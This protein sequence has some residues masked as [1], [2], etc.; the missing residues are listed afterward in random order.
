LPAD[1]I[2]T[3]YSDVP[4]TAASQLADDHL[5]LVRQWL[6]MLV[7]PADL[8]DVDFTTFVRYALGFFVNTDK[9]W[10]KD[11][12]GLH[13]IVAVPTARL[14]ILKSAHDDVAHKGFYA[15]NALIALWFWWP[16]MRGNIAWWVRTCRL[17]QLRQMRN[18]LILPVV[19]TPTSLFAKIYIDTM[20]LPKSGGYSYIVQGRCSVCH[21]V[22]FRM[23]RHKTGTTIGDWIF[24]DILCQ[25]GALTE[26]VTDNGPPFI[27]ALKYLVRKDHVRHIRISGYNL[28][29]NGLV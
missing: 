7:W 15:T 14:S 19:V 17:C 6:T 22:K 25:W 21:Y 20:H 4:H 24:E 27:K 9:L 12:R 23:L 13:K 3:S 11:P 18:I 10:H 5:E 29:A 28:H 26:I 1:K 2:P 8:S 16:Q